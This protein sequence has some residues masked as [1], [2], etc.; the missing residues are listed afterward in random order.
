MLD[1]SARLARRALSV[2]TRC[3]MSYALSTESLRY[4]FTARL[5]ALVAA[6]TSG[7]YALAQSNP[8]R[9]LPMPGRPRRP[10]PS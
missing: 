7:G 4:A 9:E 6:V 2:Q 3:F 8:A 1:R 10:R 5:L